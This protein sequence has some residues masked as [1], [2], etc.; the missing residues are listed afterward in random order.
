MPLT[1]L[2]PV[3]VCC[4]VSLLLLPD[5]SVKLLGYTIGAEDEDEPNDG[6][7]QPDSRCEA[8]PSFL[9]PHAVYPRFDDVG[10]LLVKRVDHHENLIESDV[11]NG[12]E[13]QH[14]H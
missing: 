14:Q 10:F 11:Q 8:D 13:S 7:E 5:L 12:A 3:V 2:S 9:H 1:T 6:L 4:I